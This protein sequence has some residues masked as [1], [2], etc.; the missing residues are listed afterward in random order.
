MHV[1]YRVNAPLAADHWLNDPR[2]GGG[3]ILGEA[4]HMFDFANWLCGTPIRVMAAALP[5]PPT[6][7]SVESATITVEY[8]DGSVATVLY[9]GV[10]A[11]AMPKERVEVLR[12]GRSWV[13]DDFRSLTAWDAGGEQTETSTGQ[14]KGH[15][16]L[17]APGARRVPRAAGASSRASR[18]PTRRR[19]WRSPRS[20]RS[21][22]A[23]PG[24]C[25]PRRSARTRQRRRPE[26]AADAPLPSAT[27]RG[28][29]P[30]PSSTGLSVHPGRPHVAA[31]A[32]AR[33][34]RPEGRTLRLL[35]FGVVV[36]CSGP[37]S[38]R[39]CIQRRG[40]SSRAG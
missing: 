15:A 7:G 32:L 30:E 14:D 9:S 26:A 2:V 21:L 19:A 35:A 37:S 31:R 40:S 34:D 4:C 8:A 39:A 25:P 18:P 3:R 1:V 29:M 28:R 13:L 10:G 38:C 33:L 20:T 36:A 22:P 12:G 27:V 17:H 24:P 23:T 16:E 5:A 6:V 11:G